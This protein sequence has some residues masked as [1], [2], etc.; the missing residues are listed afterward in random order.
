MVS[1]VTGTRVVMV[2]A[3][4]AIA[5][6]GLLIFEGIAGAEGDSET[7]PVPQDETTT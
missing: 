7:D 6:P 3:S 1:M 5:S 2:G 4:P